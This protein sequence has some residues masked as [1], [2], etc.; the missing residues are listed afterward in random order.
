MRAR[1]WV[2]LK[3]PL[4][5]HPFDLALCGSARRRS[6]RCAAVSPGSVGSAPQS[7]LNVAN[8]RPGLETAKETLPGQVVPM[9]ALLCGQVASLSG[10]IA[11]LDAQI[12]A[13]ARERGEFG[14]LTMVPGVASL[15][16]L[17]LPRHSAVAAPKALRP[18]G[19]TGPGYGEGGTIRRGTERSQDDWSRAMSKGTILV[20]ARQTAEI[21]PFQV[22][23]DNRGR[24]RRK[25]S[26][27]ERTAVLC[28]GDRF[29]AWRLPLNRS[30]QTR[31]TA[32]PPLS[33]F[34][35]IVVCVGPMPPIAN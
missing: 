4:R 27:D 12:R 21:P 1:S 25:C 30:H 29:F 9:A 23:V 19:A 2:T 20:K 6:I 16:P 34:D 28:D 14:R 15:V 32:P 22:A 11:G 8:P 5:R 13:R 7:A 33:K 10:Q 26:Q 18:A 31:Q 3:K 17:M 35:S 24:I